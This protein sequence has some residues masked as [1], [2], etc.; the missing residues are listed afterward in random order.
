MDAHCL[1]VQGAV[2]QI[3]QVLKEAQIDR[4]G[5][6]LTKSSRAAGEFRDAVTG[7]Q[8]TITIKPNPMK[9]CK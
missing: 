1:A 2:L 3:I 8:Y 7:Q 4:T 6:D 5:A 9:A